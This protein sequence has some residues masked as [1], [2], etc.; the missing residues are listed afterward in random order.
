MSRLRCALSGVTYVLNSDTVGRATDCLK[1]CSSLG[2]PN[3]AR[4]I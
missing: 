3:G 2:S 4:P 1:S